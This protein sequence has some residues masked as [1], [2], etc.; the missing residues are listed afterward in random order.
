MYLGS[1][2]CQLILLNSWLPDCIRA[3]SVTANHEPVQA[4]PNLLVGASSYP[5]LPRGVTLRVREQP[6]HGG[7]SAICLSAPK[8]PDQASHLPCL[9]FSQVTV[10]CGPWLWAVSVGRGKN[11]RGWPV[12]EEAQL[13]EPRH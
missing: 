1:Y 3:T 4:S 13:G 9:L 12:S 11:P 10:R 8:A 2:L 5:N 7:L 6:G